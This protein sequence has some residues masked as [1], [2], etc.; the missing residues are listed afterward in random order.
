MRER[1]HAVENEWDFKNNVYFCEFCVKEW[2]QNKH[3]LWE[4]KNV[5]G[6]CILCGSFLCEAHSLYDSDSEIRRCRDR[7]ACLAAAASDQEEGG[8]D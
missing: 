5:V 6:T 4:R 3:K 8:G 1:G 2:Q 7:N